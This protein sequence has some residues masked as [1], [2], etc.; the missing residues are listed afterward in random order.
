[1]K[2]GEDH[3]GAGELY[4]PRTM[5][6]FAGAG[7]GVLADILLGHQCVCAVEIEPYCQQVLS[8]RQK[9]GSLP[10]FP[11]FDDV[12]KFDGGPWK[13][14]IDIV[15]GGFPCQ[16]L[17]SAGKGAGLK[18][19]QS[20]LWSEMRR[21]IS[22]VRPRYAFIE[23]SPMLV[24]RGL[25]TVICDLAEM[26][27]GCRWGIISAAECG[28]HHERKRI[29][30]VADSQRDKQSRQESRIWQAGRVGRKFQYLAWNRD[31]ESALREFRGMGDGMA[32]SVDRTD[33]I[34]NGQVPAVAATA[35]SILSS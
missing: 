26:G 30:I 20:G 3:A 33:A 5:H 17:S 29:W 8:A 27:Y 18:G 31:W 12:T 19:A 32:R 10:W 21:I 35:W 34:R 25:E 2:N 6:L 15:A 16:D 13:G 14:L 23:N 7:G 22:E 11:I 4:K 28:A 9:D 24:T 1:M